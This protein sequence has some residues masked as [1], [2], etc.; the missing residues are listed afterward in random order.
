MRELE[1]IELF[2]RKGELRKA[3]LCIQKIDPSQIEKHETFSLANLCQRIGNSTLAL[4]LL[5]PYI[6][7]QQAQWEP[8]TESDLIDYAFTL[9]MIGASEAALKIFSETSPDCHP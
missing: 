9:I 8:P 7:G 3:S 1:E 4:K 6:R 2:I 5:H